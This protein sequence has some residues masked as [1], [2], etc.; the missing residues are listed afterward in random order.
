MLKILVSCVVLERGPA[1][2]H[3][4][5]AVGAL[6]HLHEA[7][8]RVRRETELRRELAHLA[9]AAA[10]RRQDEKTDSATMKAPASA[11]GRDRQLQHFRAV[12]SISACVSRLSI[13]LLP[14]CNYVL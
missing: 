14:V 7:P 12:L 8:G 9:C 11:G 13:P 1:E 6:G 2:A 5:H 10:E 4:V 3:E